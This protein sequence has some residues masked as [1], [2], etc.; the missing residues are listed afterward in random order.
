MPDEA[1]IAQLT[2]DTVKVEKLVREFLSAQTLQILPQ[3]TFGDA[4]S[5]FVDKDDRHAMDAFLTDTMKKQIE[6]L[7]KNEGDL[8][9]DQM[10]ELFDKH[11]SRLEDL[12]KSGVLK[13]RSTMRLKPKPSNWDSDMEGPWEDA[14][15]AYEMKG[16]DD[17]SQEDAAIG[18]DGE[19]GSVPPRSAAAKRGGAKATGMSTR[20][21]ATAS[22]RTAPK[23]RGGTSRAGARSKKAVEDDSDEDVVMISDQDEEEP[24]ATR[25]TTKAATNATSKRAAPAAKKAPARAAT[26][27][28][29]QP[30][31][32]QTQLN[33]SQPATQTRQAN[34]KGAARRDL[35]SAFALL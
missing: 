7:S 24:P 32:R 5:L 29:S 19:G 26:A 28:A 21:P 22:Q 10:V 35:V 23:G 27:K 14:H 20:K 30:T 15:G 17:E 33:F 18:E 3:N 4:V 31:G 1:T 11:R 16:E 25:K 12:H 8:D 13:I 2:V 9:E 6:E 34:G